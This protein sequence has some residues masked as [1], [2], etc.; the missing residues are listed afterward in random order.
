M[1]IKTVNK[2]NIKKDLTSLDSLNFL[3][4]PLNH[5]YHNNSEFGLTV[6]E[7]ENH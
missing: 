6:F 2:E 5:Y 1:Y 4:N 7:K 3:D